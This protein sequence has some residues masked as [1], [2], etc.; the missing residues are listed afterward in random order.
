[1]KQL[2][3]PLATCIA[4]GPLAVYLLLLGFINLGRRPWLTTGARDTAGLAVAVAGLIVVGPMELFLPA[5]AVG[6]FQAFVWL[7][8]ISFY[9]L[10]VTLLILVQRPRLVVYNVTA[11][12]LRPVLAEVAAQLDP[13]VRWAGS[14]LAL[15][16]QRIE[17]H[18]EALAPLRNVSLVASHDQQ[19]IEGWQRLETA[20][21]G[22][23]ARIEV[24]RNPSGALLVAASLAF[25][26]LIYWRLYSDP[27]GVA[28]A[29]FEM[30]RL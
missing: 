1:M 4:L 3:D 10:S 30:L 11:D 14:S 23:L 16:R 17:L 6:N 9:V 22:A 21:A 28:Q 5:D 25:V 13:D 15:P 24:P 19:N 12:V 26:S 18:M 8:L 27:Q 20:L 29:F 7:L 2:L